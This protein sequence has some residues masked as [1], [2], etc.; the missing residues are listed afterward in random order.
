MVTFPTH[1]THFKKNVLNP[2]DAFWDTET[3][4][5]TRD[6]DFLQ[7]NHFSASKDCP[8]KNTMLYSIE[9]QET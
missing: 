5:F 9:E 8:S 2:F 1:S 7:V 4:N 3:V 6:N